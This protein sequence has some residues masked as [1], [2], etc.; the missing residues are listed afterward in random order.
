M[1]FSHRAAALRSLQQISLADLWGIGMK[2][3]IATKLRLELGFR[4]EGNARSSAAQI[5]P[6]HSTAELYQ[7]VVVDGSSVSSR[8]QA[9]N[10]SGHP[11]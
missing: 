4:S 10:R 1:W 9:S 11:G 8:S 5:R 7:C 2:K 3:S 6:Q